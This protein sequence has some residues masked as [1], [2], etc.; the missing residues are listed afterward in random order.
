MYERNWSEKHICTYI[1]ACVVEKKVLNKKA[2]TSTAATAKNTNQYCKQGV[3]VT[4][5]YITF[6]RQG[7][8]IFLDTISQIVVKYTKLPINYGM[9]IKY[10]K[11]PLNIPNGHVFQ[12][13]ICM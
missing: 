1:R 12:M 8:Q 11:W 3:S 9:A 7:C 5:F 13:A 6:A 2:S 4:I 10:T